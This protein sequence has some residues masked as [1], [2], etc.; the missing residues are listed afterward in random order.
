MNSIFFVHKMTQVRLNLE[1]VIATLEHFAMNHRRI[2]ETR[3]EDGRP[4]IDDHFLMLPSNFPVDFAVAAKSAV[5]S[6]EQ[7]AA[8]YPK[9]LPYDLEL[10]REGYRLIES[11]TCNYYTIGT[12]MEET[13]EE[14]P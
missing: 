5:E 14:Q 1:P 6:Y 11:G 7:Y 9:D 10:V 13:W 3:L 2:E 4:C 12:P 8:E